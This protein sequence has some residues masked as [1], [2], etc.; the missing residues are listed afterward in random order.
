MLVVC[1]SVCEIE[2]PEPFEEPEIFGADTDQLY[3]VFGVL[4]GLLR[5][6]AGM[7]EPLQMV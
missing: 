6:I 7:D 3:V 5:A 2:P 4:F 1:V